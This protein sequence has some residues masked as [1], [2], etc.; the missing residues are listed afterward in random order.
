MDD[1]IEA[2][3]FLW[4]AAETTRADERAAHLAMIEFLLSKASDEQ[5]ALRLAANGR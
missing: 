5:E 4:R 3:K 2:K 1:L